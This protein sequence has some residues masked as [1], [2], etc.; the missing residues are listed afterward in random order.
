MHVICKTAISLVVLRFSA[1]HGKAY[2]SRDHGV[3]KVTKAIR[4]CGRL[5]A[6]S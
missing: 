3:V 1:S 6:D 5:S 2:D 4:V